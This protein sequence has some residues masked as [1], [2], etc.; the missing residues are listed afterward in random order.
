MYSFLTAGNEGSQLYY[1]E[2]SGEA[3]E[4]GG[5]RRWPVL[6]R[7][8]RAKRVPRASQENAPTFA[9]PA[10]PFTREAHAARGAR[11]PPLA[12]DSES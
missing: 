10:F 11:M 2:G 1:S 7:Q 9:G 8:S 3:Q 6:H 5:R 12:G 4:T